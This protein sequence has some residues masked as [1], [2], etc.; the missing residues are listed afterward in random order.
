MVR[1]G[2]KKSLGGGTYYYLEHTV[3]DGTKRT[4]RSK[5][6]GR[7]LPRDIERKKRDFASSLDKAKWFDGFDEIRRNYNKEVRSTPSSAREKALREFSVRFT[8]DT[9]RIE[10]ST[11]TLRETALLLDDKVSPGGKP[12]ADSKEAEAHARLFFEMLKFRGEL[13]LNL[14]EEWNW[15]LLGET[16]P[17]IAGKVRR[18]GV[19]ISGSKFEPPS[20][21]ELQLMLDEFFSWYR[22]AKGTLNPV[23]LAGLVHLKFVTIHP[24]TDGNGR[25]SRLMMNYV[26]Q[27]HGYPMLNIPYKR[28]A[29]YYRALERSQV[30]KDERPFRTWFFRQY[31]REH[32]RL[33]GRR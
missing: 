9:Q 18:R 23:E 5:Y 31:L 32:R 15:R 25:V 10:G 21:V 26:L 33:L 8:Y 2:K 20:P 3:R 30:S 17:D 1:V 24:F 13:S 29:G 19:R 28:R 11:L 16:K 7:R 27:R 6:L 14:V 22:Q 4:T 12:I